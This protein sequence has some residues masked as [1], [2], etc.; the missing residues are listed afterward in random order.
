MRSD[1]DSS[2]DKVIDLDAI[3]ASVGDL[4]HYARACFTTDELRALLRGVKRLLRRSV[5]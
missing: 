5:R 2:P 1:F 4:I 3:D